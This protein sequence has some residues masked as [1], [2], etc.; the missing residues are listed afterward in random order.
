VWPYGD[1]KHLPAFDDDTAAAPTDTATAKLVNSAISSASFLSS[2]WDKM[3]AAGGWCGCL[4]LKRFG[5]GSHLLGFKVSCWAL[6]VFWRLRFVCYVPVA[7]FEKAPILHFY[8]LTAGTHNSW[9][10][11]LLAQSAGLK[12]TKLLC[13]A[14]CILA[15]SQFN[16]GSN[17]YLRLQNLL[18][19]T[20]HLFLAGHLML[21]ARQPH[22]PQQQ[23][24]PS[25]MTPA[26]TACG[27][28][29]PVKF[30]S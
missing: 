18:C 10:V 3:R 25:T 26:S 14:D 17:M 30:H 28:P 20:P 27:A 6:L 5:T 12:Y 16:T 24:V 8:Q 23:L 11:W 22:P 29:W 21:Q 9:Y 19:H 15:H 4:L 2:G 1:L 13:L 7:I